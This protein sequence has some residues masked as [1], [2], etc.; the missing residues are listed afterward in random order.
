M[1]NKILSLFL[2]STLLIG[3]I[4]VFASENLSETKNITIN[5][6]KDNEFLQIPTDI[7]VSADLSE[8]YNYTTNEDITE[9]TVLDALIAIHIEMYGEDFKSSPTDY[10]VG[11]SWI[12]RAFGYDTYTGFSFAVNNECPHDGVISDY[13]TYTGYTA[14]ETILAEN[15]NVSFFFNAQTSSYSDFISYFDADIKKVATNQE[16]LLNLKGYNYMTYGASPYLDNYIQNIENAQ[17]YIVSNDGTLTE[18]SNKKTDANGN[19]SLSFDEIGTYYITA[20]AMVET[21][22]YDWY[23]GA[24]VDAEVPIF[25]PFIEV[26]VANSSVV[27]YLVINSQYTNTNTYGSGFEDILTGSLKSLGNF[28]GFVTFYYDEPLINDPNNMYGVDFYVYGNTYVNNSS[29]AEPGQVWISEDNITW[30]ALAGSE[31]YENST[32]KDYE[33]TYSK[34]TDG[35][36]SWTDS[37]GNSDISD[38]N[39]PKQEYYPLFNITDEITL[40]GIYLQNDDINATN[41][42][43]GYV[44]ALTNGE[45]G[46]NVNPYIKNP[47]S[48]SGFDILWAV[49]E[50]NMPVDVSNMEF[51]YVKVVTASNIIASGIGEKS[52]EISGIMRTTPQNN[53]VG[54]TNSIAGITVNGTEIAFNENTAKYELNI[55]NESVASISINGADNSDN[56]Y[57]N[58]TRVLANEEVL[59]EA[60]AK[61]SEFIRII[62]QNDEKEPIIYMVELTSDAILDID[63]IFVNSNST[64]Y[65]PTSD[66]YGNYSLNVANSVSNIEILVESLSDITINDEEIQQNYDLSVGNNVFNIKSD[67]QEITL[68]VSRASAPTSSSSPSVSNI[69]V[70]VKIY[71]IDDDNAD[72]I[73]SEN[74]QDFTNILNSNIEIKSGSSAWS[75]IENALNSAK[76][77]YINESGTY[78][79]SVNGLAE[80]DCGETSGWLYKINGK[81][82]EV[83]MNDYI[84]K[85]NDE[86]ILHYTTNFSLENFSNEEFEENNNDFEEN[87]D[88][89]EENNMNFEDIAETDWYYDAVKYV[90]ENNIFNGMSETEFVPNELMTRKMAVTV[91]H[92]ISDDTEYNSGGFWYTDGVNWAKDLGISDVNNL[93]GSITREQF[94]TMLYRFSNAETTDFNIE[95]YTDSN[96][97]SEWA[98]DAMKWAIENDIIN[99]VTE[100]TLKPKNT[101]TRAEVA[102]ILMRFI[103]IN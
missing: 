97:I 92:R 43:F 82:L 42:S 41:I 6:Q 3:N 55:G 86:I 50:N 83:S 58:N 75:A 40:N 93:D 23:E 59:F 72:Y 16:F 9:P 60:T 80:L 44:D 70:N 29:F 52:T 46:E 2:A 8:I 67:N 53:S 100:T 73:F 88:N 69:D 63:N 84:L 85:N 27:D 48:A 5:V 94:V 45:I 28:G 91:L 47:Q 1:K 77:P 96:Q 39:Y 76:M 21:S 66:I 11:A 32:I 103:A 25:M 31:H 101:A 89:S 15:D 71:S 49:D 56:I 62:V 7:S 22:I 13:G 37:L 34:T 64:T 99:G 90:V 18:I 61:S 12:S 4:P 36:T 19:V 26:N 79:T 95:N 35:K 65:Q 57:I 38:Y 10:L 74:P 78:L 81:Y 20:K 33:I 24:Y 54:V 51:H 87:N 14:D 17:L 68:T 30:Y 98:V 102:T